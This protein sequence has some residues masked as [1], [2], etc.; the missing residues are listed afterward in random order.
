MQE[1]QLFEHKNAIEAL[2]IAHQVVLNQLK[3]EHCQALK[4]QQEQLQQEYEKNKGEFMENCLSSPH[5]ITTLIPVLIKEIEK[6]KKKE[7]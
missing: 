4:L 7:V 3:D 2:Q 6:R 1:S 5:H